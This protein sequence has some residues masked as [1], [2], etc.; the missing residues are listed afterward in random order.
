MKKL[1]LVVMLFIILISMTACSP[2]VRTVPRIKKEDLPES[3]EGLIPLVKK[4]WKKNRKQD[5]YLYD[6]EFLKKLQNDYRECILQLSLEELKKL[7][8]NTPVKLFG[9]PSGEWG[10][11]PYLFYLLNPGCIGYPQDCEL[12]IFRIKNGVVKEVYVR[13][14]EYIEGKN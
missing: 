10:T 7:F 9:D 8:G 12:L 2:F 5:Y 13:K 4:K 1:T 14:H 6:K 3:C 11:E